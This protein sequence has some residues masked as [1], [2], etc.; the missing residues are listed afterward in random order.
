MVR[1]KLTSLRDECNTSWDC[2][3]GSPCE[4]GL[5][6][7]FQTMEIKH[8]DPDPHW[9]LQCDSTPK[10]I[11]PTVQECDWQ[12]RR[13]LQLRINLVAVSSFSPLAS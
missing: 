6:L 1:Q 4:K 7:R 9:Q 5:M 2:K 12:A 8:S 10:T 11:P 3:Q 13:V